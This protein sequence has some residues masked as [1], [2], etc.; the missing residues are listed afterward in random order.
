MTFLFYLSLNRVS[1]KKSVTEL[2]QK[3]EKK[4]HNHIITLQTRTLVWKLARFFVQLY[5][6]DGGFLLGEGVSCGLARDTDLIYR[7]WMC[8][9]HEDALFEP[10]H[11]AGLLWYQ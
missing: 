7:A 2:L 5:G 4:K 10:N 11:L 9:H 3:K 1:I 6:A 8:H